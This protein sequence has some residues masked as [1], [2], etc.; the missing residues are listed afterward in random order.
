M[1]KEVKKTHQACPWMK[2]WEILVL[3]VWWRMLKRDLWIV[4]CR[5][6]PSVKA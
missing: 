6:V 1:E 3:L 2:I 5:A 4:A